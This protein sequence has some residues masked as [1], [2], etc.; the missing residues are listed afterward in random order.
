MKVIKFGNESPQ[1]TIIGGIHGDEPSGVEIIHMLCDYLS[2]HKINGSVKLI[3]ANEKALKKNVR[4]IEKDVNRLFPGNLN[5]EI[6]EERL[7]AKIFSEIQNSNFVL[8]LHSTKSSPPPFAIY[9]KLTDINK[10]SLKNMHINYAVDCSELNG[11]T[12]DSHFDNAVTLECGK[13]QS[14]KAI[15]F[16]FKSTKNLLRAHNIITDEQS[17]QNTVNIVKAK[18][19][20]PKGNGNSTVY[21]NNFEKIQ[22]DTVFAD[23]NE[24]EH[25]I[26]ETDW[27]PILASEDGYENIYGLLGKFT[28]VI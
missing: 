28:N 15:D 2:N 14:Q 7:A 1:I 25:I 5:G 12:L 23:D 6:Y 26:H 9:S 11:N 17:Q 3:I 4:Y 19:E 22:K 10:K 13:Q 20:I 24:Y 16:G 27:V 18:K 8:A 21:Y